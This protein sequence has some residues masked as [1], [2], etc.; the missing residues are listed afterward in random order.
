MKRGTC[1]LI[2]SFTITALFITIATGC[3]QNNKPPSNDASPKAQNISYKQTAPDTSLPAKQNRTKNN[4]DHLVQL[5]KQVPQVKEASAIVLGKY[6]V[7]AIDVNPDLD[8]ARVGTVKYAVAQA[9]RDDPQ[10]K[11]ALVTA[12]VDLLHRIKKMNE[13]ISQGRPIAGIMNELGAIVARIAPQPSNEVK[14]RERDET[15]QDRNDTHQ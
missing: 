4:S 1:R 3:N 11:S 14:K 12:D 5:A 2:S 10:G 13:E 7:V 8:S 6:A 9:L 15:K